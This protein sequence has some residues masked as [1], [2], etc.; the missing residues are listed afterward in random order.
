MTTVATILT[1]A[2]RQSNLVAAGVEPTAAETAEALRYL[3]RIVKSVFGAEAGENLTAIPVGS[4]T[5]SRPSG[6][7]WYD[8]VP[9]QDWFVPTN[10]RLISNLDQTLSL[11]LHP[12]PDDGSRFAFIDSKGDISANPVTVYGNG[13][14]IE[15][16]PS[17]VIGTDRTDS[18]WFFRADLANWLKTAPLLSIDTFPF[19]E[20]FDD[21]FITM[22]A[23]RLNPSYGVMLDQQSDLILK[24]STRQ[25][26]ARYV[27]NKPIHSEIGLLRLT[28]MAVDR[29]R[30]NSYYEI[31]DPNAM[32]V[33][34][35]PY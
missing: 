8:T 3:N 30:W 24:R 12:A 18:E 11:Y 9:D 35:W 16:A 20:E 26:K 27:Q 28:K 34:G 10:V 7:P 32:F 15:D 33:K 23:I 14:R 1:D 22:L 25:L 19:P 13:H 31:Y 6:Y 29:D 17:I 2:F 21:F 4:D 5:I